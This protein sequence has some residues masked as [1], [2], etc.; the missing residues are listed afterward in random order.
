MGKNKESTLEAAK[1]KLDK[2]GSELE[3]NPETEQLSVVLFVLAGSTLLGKEAMKSIA[4]WNA[5]WADSVINEVDKMREE[6]K[7]ND[8]TDKIIQPPDNNE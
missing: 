8:L 5:T 1:E 4:L 2:L 3:K 7:V 6:E